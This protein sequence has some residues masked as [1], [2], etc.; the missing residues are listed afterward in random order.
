MAYEAGELVITPT[1]TSTVPITDEWVI[2]HKPNTLYITSDKAQITANGT[3]IATITVQLRTPI[4]TDDTYDN[5]SEAGDV[6]ILV[7]GVADV[8]TLNAIG[9]GTTTVASVEVGTFN[10]KG[11]SLDSN[12][13]QLEAI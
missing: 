1:G 7:D 5:V 4:L 8:V 12:I 11:D 2:A 13:L 9:T 3:D 6:T 10:I